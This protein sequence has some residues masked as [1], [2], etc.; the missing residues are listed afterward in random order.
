MSKSQPVSQ[1]DESTS[2]PTRAVNPYK[3]PSYPQR[4]HIHERLHWQGVVTSCEEGIANTRA[5]IAALGPEAANHPTMERLYAQMIGARD[6]VADAARRLPGETGDLYEED[7]H[8]VEEGVAAMERVRR[9][10]EDARKSG[11]LP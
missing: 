11:N 4:D 1:G 9:Q 8:R 7:K 10:W 2:A 6:Q 3:N 5:A